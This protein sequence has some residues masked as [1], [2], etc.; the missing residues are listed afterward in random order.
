MR[1]NDISMYK[2]IME[3]AIGYFS[4]RAVPENV[5]K[6]SRYFKE[7]Y[8]AWGCADGTAKNAAGL[9]CEQYP[10]LTLM[11]IIELGDLLFRHGKY[12]TGSLAIQ[13]LAGREKEFDRETFRG[14]KGWFDHG[15]GNWAHSDVL[16][17]MITPPFITKGIVAY[18]DMAD[19]LKSPSRWTRRAVP[20]TLL[21]IRKTQQPEEL[22]AF[23]SPLMLDTERVVHQG[24]GWFLRE[25]WKLHP[26]PVE[27]LLYNHRN[28]AARLIIQY[29][30][31]KMTK[32][33]KER[34]RRER[35]K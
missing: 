28:T 27:E 2:Q 23:L 7:G 35:K 21:C 9:I 18:T 16:C 1:V 31:E 24:M 12:E 30:T 14:V 4:E 26:R 10:D 32:E 22:I 25:L 17:S 6:Y 8:D 3:F 34:F 15:V 20:V 33:Q 13:L 5:V 19:W 11:Q 29:A